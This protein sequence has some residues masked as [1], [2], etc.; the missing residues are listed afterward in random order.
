[1]TSVDIKSSKGILTVLVISSALAGA[2]TTMI[3]QQAVL[4]KE[5]SHVVTELRSISSSMS[6][7]GATTGEHATKISE[8]STRIA[9]VEKELDLLR[10]Y[11]AAPTP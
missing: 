3:T 7:L 10:T 11:H 5:M 6:N 8:I 4:A 1:M 2:G 9:V